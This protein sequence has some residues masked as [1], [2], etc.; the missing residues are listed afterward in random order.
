M[1]PTGGM[2]P[3]DSQ[4]VAIGEV[5]RAPGGRARAAPGRFPGCRFGFFGCIKVLPLAMAG[6][7]DSSLLQL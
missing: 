7:P 4:E 2:Q 1:L 5:T 6:I 3:P